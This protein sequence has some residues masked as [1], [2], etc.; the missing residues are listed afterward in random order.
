MLLLL[1][2]L[3]RHLQRF[4]LGTCHAWAHVPAE[5]ILVC[6]SNNL[7]QAR[8][9]EGL[10]NPNPK[11]NLNHSLLQ[12]APLLPVGKLQQANCYGLATGGPAR[13]YLY[14]QVGAAEGLSYLSGVALSG[15]ALTWRDVRAPSMST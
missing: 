11:P 10:S 9:A 5:S 7:L 8:A 14:L 4:T 1:G 13:W 6:A 15:R 2:V 12:W 3:V